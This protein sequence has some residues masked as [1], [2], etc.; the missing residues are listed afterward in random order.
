MASN[1]QGDDFTQWATHELRHLL[2][3][4]LPTLGISP[5]AVLGAKIAKAK[6]PKLICLMIGT[7]VFL[8]CFMSPPNFWKNRQL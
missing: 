7:I 4:E 8:N 1:A 3:Q 5:K 2:R 6:L